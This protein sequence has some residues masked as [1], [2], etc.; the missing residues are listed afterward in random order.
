MGNVSSVS[1]ATLEPTTATST[2]L[3]EFELT[4]YCRSKGGSICNDTELDLNNAFTIDAKLNF[5]ENNTNSAYVNG[6]DGI[7]FVLQTDPRSTSA[8]TTGGSIGY[9][10]I[11]PSVAFEFDTYYNGN[12]S[13]VTNDHLAIQLDVSQ[14]HTS[15][16][17]VG[18]IFGLGEIEDGS[19]YDFRITWDPTIPQ[20]EVWLDQENTPQGN[21]A[22]KISNSYNLLGKFSAQDGVVFWGF[23]A[24]TGAEYNRQRVKD[25]QPQIS[26]EFS[27]EETQYYNC[28]TYTLE[29]REPTITGQVGVHLDS[30]KIHP[31]SSPGMSI[32]P[33]TGVITTQNASP[34]L[35]TITFTFTDANGN[36]CTTTTD[37][38]ILIE[39]PDFK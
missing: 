17:M 5:G 13:D 4:P 1:D 21:R 8:A 19:W 38:E 27:Y 36:S 26:V 30:P 28:L 32:D 2:N 10:G 23:T 34:G 6:S 22:A 37:V 16:N 39:D 15:G 20:L 24:S 29:D 7:A 9:A 14:S 3:D 31:A 12:N 25:I 35:Y 11:S 18:N 33:N